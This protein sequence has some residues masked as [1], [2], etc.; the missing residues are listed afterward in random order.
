MSNGIRL[1]IAIIIF[2]CPFLI[3]IT[4]KLSESLS[5]IEIAEYAA[6]I[7]G[8]K[9]AG[10]RKDFAQSGGSYNSNEDPLTKI[11]EFILSKV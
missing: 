7:S 6:S 3:G 10:G 5:A 9:G 11:K 4:N 1:N 8:G 2:T